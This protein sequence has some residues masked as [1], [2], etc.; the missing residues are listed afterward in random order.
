MDGCDLIAKAV[1]ERVYG[2]V[3]V[4]FDTN[5]A[6]IRVVCKDEFYVHT[7]SWND[8]YSVCSNGSKFV[9]DIFCDRYYESLSARYGE[10]FNSS[11]YFICDD[12][13]TRL[14]KAY[15][16]MRKAKMRGDM[17]NFVVK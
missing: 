17:P 14:R 6:Q 4:L 2:D 5:H 7:F 15:I 12:K 1:S 10:R 8:W 3:A 9:A 13:E 16:S 11:K